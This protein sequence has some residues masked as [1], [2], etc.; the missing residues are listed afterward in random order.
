MGER[1]IGQFSL[2]SGTGAP[3][4]SSAG[5]PSF[6]VLPMGD[7]DEET[8]LPT[9]VLAQFDPAQ[10]RFQSDNLELFN[11]NPVNFF[12]GAL[13][14]TQM[15]AMGR[16]ELAPIAEVYGEFQFMDNTRKAQLAESGSFF[17]NFDVSLS[18]PFLTEEARQQICQIRGGDGNAQV[19]PENCNADNETDTVTMALRR[20]FV[21]L[22]PRLND[23]D[24]Q[25]FQWTA[26]IRG[27]LSDFAPGWDYDIY[28]SRGEAEQNQVRGN[29]GSLSA[30][31][32]ALQATTDADGN[33]VCN[34]TSGGCVPLNLFGPAGSITEEMLR[35]INLDAFLSQNVR[36][37]VLSASVSGDLGS[38]TS[39]W[40]DGAPIGVAF[41]YEQREVTA[42]TSSD[43]SSQIDSEVL[44]TGAAT[45]DRSGSF[46][47]DEFYV[48]MLA[49]VLPTVTL[50][51]GYRQTR[52]KVDSSEN[53][54]SWKY[55][56]AWEP[57]DGLRFRAMFQRATR[58]PNINELFQ[59]LVTGLSN[60]DT[61]PCQGG[62]I[63]AGQANTEGTL[64][65]LC[66]QT[67]IPIGAIGGL[68]APA[69]GQINQLEGGNPGLGPEEADTFTVGF[70]YQ[71]DFVRDLTLT[72]DYFNIQIDDQVSSPSTSD[73]LDQCF[74]PALN[75]NF[76]FNAS[77]AQVR[78]SPTTGDLNA[79]DSPGVI[80]EISNLG[81]SKTTGLDFGAVYGMDLADWGFG[82]NLGRVAFS[83]N[84][85]HVL[86][87]DFQ[88]T[89]ASTNRDCVGFFSIACNDATGSGMI[90]ETKFNQRTT[91]SVQDFD[92]SLNWRR[93]SKMKIEPGAGNFLE[94]FSTID[95]TNYLDFS[96][97]W[98]PNDN[99][100]VNL[101]INNM[102][103]KSPPNVGDTIGSTAANSGNTFP[104]FYD[105]IGRFYTVGL[106]VSF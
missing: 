25:Q 47:L 45:P 78:R 90:H 67:G 39:P 16:Y 23:F 72:V 98:R 69:A 42:S 8:G 56:G 89:P 74:D 44:G 106:N 91:W 80:T 30:V 26:G 81:K 61:D 14:R 12:Q 3:S 87:F 85:T 94:E 82:D 37:D 46:K 59:P 31:R 96:G 57:M 10:G 19:A 7:I 104:Q 52:F 79:G 84:L 5:V 73:I 43:A 99:I 102:F 62:L 66:R 17:N 53:Y 60:L 58:A 77:C 88:A 2:N 49:P 50:E 100:R 83:M 92:L 36:Q 97:A 35:F 28:F 29:W 22:G 40:S 54:G 95:A 75:P 34:D 63:S 1:S 38:F 48:E 15:T 32:Q 103:D 64:S 27:D 86:D 24:N 20:R 51:A 65:N 105:V 101:T 4:G 18:N 6:S 68:P 76:S 33:P 11:F 41:G 9:N 55:G 13:E 93:L 70:V 21:E 71:P